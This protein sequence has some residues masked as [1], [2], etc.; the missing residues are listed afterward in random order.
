[1]ALLSI[2]LALLLISAQLGLSL[3]LPLSEGASPTKMTISSPLPVN[4]SRCKESLVRSMKTVLLRGLNLERAPSVNPQLTH[5]LRV[6]W[7]A[8][9][10]LLAGETQPE[11]QSLTDTAASAVSTHTAGQRDC[12]QTVSISLTDLGWENWIIHPEEFPYI[13]CTN[14]RAGRNSQSPHCTHDQQRHTARKAKCC[15]NNRRTWV[16]VV[17]ID[18]DEGLVTSNVPLTA[19]CSCRA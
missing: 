17:Y 13:L 18:A 5:S 9:L 2:P 12:C 19:R 10:G 7:R 16:S 11:S 4:M 3:A 8:N 15:R 14:C 1:M 6:M